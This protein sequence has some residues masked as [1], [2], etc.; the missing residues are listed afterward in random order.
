MSLWNT[1]SYQAAVLNN[2]AMLNFLANQGEQFLAGFLL[3]V[4]VC[5]RVCAGNEESHKLTPRRPHAPE[6]AV[7]NGQSFESFMNINTPQAFLIII[8]PVVRY[9]H[10]GGKVGNLLVSV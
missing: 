9:Y 2:A 10:F 5:L 7:K 8:S 4:C 3:F 6:R 1:P